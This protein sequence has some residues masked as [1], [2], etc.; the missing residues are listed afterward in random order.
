MKVLVEHRAIPVQ[1][2]LK[3]ILETLDH[4]VNGAVLDSRDS[5]DHKEQLEMLV[6][7]D[8]LEILDCQGPLVKAG[9]LDNLGDLV[10]QDHRDQRVS[11]VQ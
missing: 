9:R 4:P 1:Q 6:H 8:R 3:E 5:E 11:E 10:N 7:E 2:D